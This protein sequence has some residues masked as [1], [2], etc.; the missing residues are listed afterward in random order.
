MAHGPRK[1]SRK[2]KPVQVGKWTP[3]ARSAQRLKSSIRPNAKTRKGRLSY[4]NVN[5]SEYKGSDRIFKGRIVLDRASGMLE[6][7]NPEQFARIAKQEKVPA[8]Q[9]Q[10]AFGH[11]LKTGRKTSRRSKPKTKSRK[12][13]RRGRARRT[14]KRR[15]KTSRVKKNAKRRR[16]HVRRDDVFVPF[17]VSGEDNP[18]KA[19]SAMVPAQQVGVFGA[20]RAIMATVGGTTALLPFENAFTVLDA[21][22]TKKEFNKAFGHLRTGQALGKTERRRPIPTVFGPRSMRL[23]HREVPGEG[24]AL[25]GIVKGQL[26]LYH[27]PTGS[28]IWQ[29]YDDE[30]NYPDK[31]LWI[32]FG[33]NKIHVDFPKAMTGAR[34][35]RGERAEMVGA[36]DRGIPPMAMLQAFDIL[37]TPEQRTE[38]YNVF[39]TSP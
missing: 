18:L 15:R 23:G 9:V 22:L 38:A 37:L 16:K 14:S 2:P 24:P 26:V 32:W 29:M 12:T 39:S 19:I 8:E 3:R 30:V 35:G 4:R 20:E 10:I 27:K 36:I 25:P 17:T 6:F 28:I 7:P 1:T 13:S 11:L 31:P 21:W 34:V 33:A 5:A